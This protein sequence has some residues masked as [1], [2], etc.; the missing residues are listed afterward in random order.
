[1]AGRKLTR[2]APNYCYRCGNQA[3]IMEI[4]EHLKYTLYVSLTDIRPQFF[5][6]ICTAYNLIPALVQESQWSL[7]VP[8]IISCDLSDR[9][10]FTCEF[11]VLPPFERASGT[12][13]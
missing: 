1:V 6:N 4:D 9:F 2:L 5:T 3:A 13:E 10:P 8:R 7:D 12:L 11:E